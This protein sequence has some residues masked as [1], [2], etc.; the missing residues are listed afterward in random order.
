MQRQAG[1]TLLEVML[2]LLMLGMVVAMIGTSLSSSLKVVEATSQQGRIYRQAAI[3]MQRLVDDLQGATLPSWR[4]VGET[5]EAEQDRTDT[6]SY[7]TSA[8]LILDPEFQHAGIAHVQYVVQED[9]DA[10]GSY[11]LYRSD[12]LLPPLEEPEDLELKPGF[13]LCDGLKSL[14]LTY[15]SRD[16]EEYD[17]W[18]SSDENEE[19]MNNLL[20]AAVRIEMEF[21]LDQEA[22]QAII[23]L[24]SAPLPTGLY[25]P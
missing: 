1:F 17:Y 16:G 22:E 13:P 23:F 18:D 24:A 7:A 2:S 21:W 10:P 19:A 25:V 9:T 8:H 6:L 15:I 5:V 3:A 20:P 11:I 4:F 14:R 12:T